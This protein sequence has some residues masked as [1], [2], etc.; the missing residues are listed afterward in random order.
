M[1]HNAD[2]YEKTIKELRE[3]M[4]NINGFGNK[5]DNEVKQQKN[6]DNMAPMYQQHNYTKW[7]G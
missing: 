2:G 5:N 3:K 6:E 4:A 1:V 7:K